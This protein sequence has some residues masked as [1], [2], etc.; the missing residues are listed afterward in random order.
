MNIVILIK[1]LKKIINY[2]RNTFQRIIS[3]FPLEEQDIQTL[4]NRNIRVFETKFVS[5]IL[6]VYLN[7]NK[8]NMIFEGKIVII[9]FKSFQTKNWGASDFLALC[10]QSPII[11]LDDLDQIDLSDKNLAR[12]FI[13]FIG[14]K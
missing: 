7:K 6:D 8:E 11:L 12:R 1:Y 14:N 2:D 9:N 3:F 5:N 4:F 13:L 10:E